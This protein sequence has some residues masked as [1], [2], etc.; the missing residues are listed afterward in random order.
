VILHIYRP[1]RITREGGGREGSEEKVWQDAVEGQD[2]VMVFV[3]WCKRSLRE[4]G[5]TW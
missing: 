4:E 3:S 5:N 1:S 2:E